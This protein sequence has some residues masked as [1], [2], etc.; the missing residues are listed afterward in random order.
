MHYTNNDIYLG[1]ISGTSRDGVD[2][3]LVSFEGN[4]PRLHET[5]C[6]PYPPGLAD[7][8]KNMVEARQK[9]AAH[10]LEKLDVRLGDFFSQAALALLEKAGLGS[11][12]I[13]AIGSHGQTVWHEPVGAN[14]VSIQLGSPQRIANKTGIVTIGDFRCAD[15]EAGGQGA[16]LAPLLHRALFQPENGTRAVLNLGGIANVSILKGNFIQSGI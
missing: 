11:A 15:I 12:D 5:Q 13:T 3:V 6:L 1:M 10:E 4:L 9:P 16:P 7:A 2:T 8:L 14:P